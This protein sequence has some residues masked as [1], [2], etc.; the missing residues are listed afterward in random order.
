MRRLM[1]LAVVV[2]MVAVGC[3]SDGVSRAEHDLVVSEL[4]LANQELALAQ[5]ELT[6]ASERLSAAEQRVVDAVE[7]QRAAEAAT[8]EAEERREELQDELDELF[9]IDASEEETMERQ[10]SLGVLGNLF[11]EFRDGPW[12]EQTVAMF[13]EFVPA[14]ADER[15]I[16]QLEAFAS[17]VAA[18][19]ESKQANYEYGVLGYEIMSALERA[20]IDPFGR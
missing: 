11:V 10:Q 5:E 3:G 17:T 18:D 19:P 9:T 13:G 16:E 2:A 15:I 1:G 12:D 14:T 20:V 6:L 8:V 4:A 7:D